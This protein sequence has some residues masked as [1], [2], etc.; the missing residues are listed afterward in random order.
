M[1]QVSRSLHIHV[2]GRFDQDYIHN[3]KM[4]NHLFHASLVLVLG[5]HVIPRNYLTLISNVSGFKEHGL[6]RED[7]EKTDRQNYDMIFSDQK[8]KIPP[9]AGLDLKII[10]SMP[11]NRL[12]V[13]RVLNSWNMH[14]PHEGSDRQFTNQLLPFEVQGEMLGLIH[15]MSHI[16]GNIGH[17]I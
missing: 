11:W 8:P 10:L 13:F 9:T 1:L 15:K 17:E 2:H 7:T 16:D 5:K 14:I 12:R 4:V 3:H 6:L